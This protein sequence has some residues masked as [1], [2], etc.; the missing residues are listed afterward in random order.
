M[1]LT[2]IYGQ[3]TPNTHYAESVFVFDSIAPYEY[4]VEHPD[5]GKV[6]TEVASR[7][8]SGIDGQSIDAAITLIEY[9]GY[10][11]KLRYAFLIT[12]CYFCYPYATDHTRTDLRGKVALLGQPIISALYSLMNEAILKTNNKHILDLFDQITDSD[13][14]YRDNL[15]KRVWLSVDGSKPNGDMVDVYGYDVPSN[16]QE[17]IVLIVNSIETAYHS[18][19]KGSLSGGYIHVDTIE[20]ESFCYRNTLLSVTLSINERTTIDLPAICTVRRI[21]YDV[22]EDGNRTNHRS[23]VL[24]GLVAFCGWRLV[25]R[26]QEWLARLQTR[27]PYSYEIELLKRLELDSLRLYRSNI[28]HYACIPEYDRSAVIVRDLDPR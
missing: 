22:D 1:A 2:Y 17:S 14:F 19:R 9:V 7:R 24:D 27:L 13:R 21:T 26:L 18:S 25:Y 8:L 12:R 6:Y 23:V 16:P 3:D 11:E 10:P 15:G 28:G 4:I 20:L 5:H